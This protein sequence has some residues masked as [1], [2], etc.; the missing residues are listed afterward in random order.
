MND[1]PI[2]SFFDALFDNEDDKKIIKLLSQGIADE[3]IVEIL[4]GI[5]SGEEYL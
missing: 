1:N 3:E 2:V 5:K 4:L